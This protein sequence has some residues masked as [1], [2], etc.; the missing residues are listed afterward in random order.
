VGTKAVANHY[1]VGTKLLISEI[2]L[3]KAIVGRALAGHGVSRRE[4]RQL[5]QTAR[6]VF[7]LVPMSIFVIV[8]FMELLLPLALK[9]FPNMLPSTFQDNLKKEEDMKKELQLRL[10]VATFMQ[11]TLTEMAA[12]A[13]N[14]QEQDNEI[15]D[16]NSSAKEVIEFIE[17]ARKGE[18][19]PNKSV[20]KMARLFQDELTLSNISRPQLVSMCRYMGLS[21]YGGDGMLRY[22][23]R[24]TLRSIKEDDRSILWEGID[25]LNIQEIRD[26]CAE[27][28]MRGHGLTNFAYKRQ[29]SEWLDL[30]TQKNVPIAL[31]I[32]SRA[33]A[34]NDTTTFDHGGD[35]LKAS[36]SS[37]DSDV[38][39]EVVLAAARKEEEDTVDI[40]MRR[41]ESIQFQNEMIQAE[42]EDGI[43]TVVSGD[44]ETGSPGAESVDSREKLEEDHEKLL[45]GLSAPSSSDESTETKQSEGKG[46]SSDKAELSLAEMEAL[47]DLARG[48]AV[49]REKL[50]FESI[51]AMIDGDSAVSSSLNNAND[52]VK[53]SGIPF[54]FV[55]CHFTLKSPLFKRQL[56]QRHLVC[57]MQE[58]RIKPQR[59]A[60]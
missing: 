55:V 21:P 6:D 5:I 2:K 10:E 4:R 23:L 57:T 51:K 25:S 41:L 60:I 33:F 45:T 31:L 17:M 3:A 14:A 9:L 44:S 50:K 53:I 20:L 29:L 28:G 30:S 26:A 58:A 59:K 38:I 48:S 13:P 11:E 42:R 12:K 43:E 18:A 49:E 39:N 32:M 36:I 1:W 56:K 47:G 46:G 15:S 16:G 27:R 8:P 34:I 24:S 35:E 40:K 52:D 19:L 7:R 37:L 54:H 22:Q